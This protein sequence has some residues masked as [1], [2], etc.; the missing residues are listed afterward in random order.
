MSENMTGTDKDD[1]E[2]DPR[3]LASFC[4]EDIMVRYLFLAN[5]GEGWQTASPFG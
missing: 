5:Y 4:C 2:I 1:T 3:L